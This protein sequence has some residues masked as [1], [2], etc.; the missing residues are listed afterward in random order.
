MSY[1]DLTDLTNVGLPANALGNLTTV[2]Q[3][4]ALDAATDDMATYFGGR[5]PMPLVTW[6]NSVREKCAEI[7]AY[8]LMCLRGFNPASGADVNF[9]L[10]YQDAIKWCEGVRN[11]AIH[12]T[13]TFSDLTPA[14]AQPSVTT[15]SMV[16]TG[17]G[18]GRQ[19]GW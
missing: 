16:T 11:K 12:P 7:A 9:R 5:Y 18:V 4:K 8:K 13:V 1:A 14:Y 10:R 17:G 15:S 6:D 3:Q 19:R 2:Q